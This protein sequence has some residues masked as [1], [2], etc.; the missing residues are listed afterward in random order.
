MRP[1]K[2]MSCSDEEMEKRTVKKKN[3]EER[4]CLSMSLEASVKDESDRNSS[5]QR[6]S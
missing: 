1:L 3:G 2:R 6:T 5:G 4:R